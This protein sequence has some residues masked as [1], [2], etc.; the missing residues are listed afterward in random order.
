M[1][2][3]DTFK[4]GIPLY[5]PLCGN[6]HEDIQCKEYSNTLA[7]YQIGDIVLDV[8]DKYK[9]N[10]IREEDLICFD[11]NDYGTTCKDIQKS[12][13]RDDHTW[14]HPIYFYIV[15]K[16]YKYIGVMPSLYLAEKLIGLEEDEYY[17]NRG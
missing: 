6:K 3:F 12:L 1:G 13:F 16:D 14:R 15:I 8:N 5:C 10:E 17:L 9:G 11:E 4:F 7:Y 2:I